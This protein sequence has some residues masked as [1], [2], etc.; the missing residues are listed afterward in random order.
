LVGT[1]M[2]HWWWDA[3]RTQIPIFSDVARALDQFDEK[4]SPMMHFYFPFWTERPWDIPLNGA[5]AA[6]TRMTQCSAEYVFRE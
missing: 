2:P 3:G 5:P 6:L 1:S 4:S